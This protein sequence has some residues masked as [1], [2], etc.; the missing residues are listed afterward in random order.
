MTASA[1]DALPHPAGRVPAGPSVDAQEVAGHKA[2]RRKRYVVWQ[3]PALRVLGFA[4]LTLVVVADQASTGALRWWQVGP[5]AL[6]FLGYCMGSWLAIAAAYPRYP[7]VGQVFLAIDPFVWM[8]AVHVTGGSESWLYFLPLV[9]VADQLNSTRRL[10][11]AFAAIAVA[12]YATLLAY[13]ELV[14]GEAL[15]WWTQLGRLGF[16]AGCG[17]YL[18]VTAGTAERLRAQ[19]SD[20][21]RTARESVHRLEHQSTLLEEARLVAEEANR[22]KSEFLANVSHE[23][24]TPLNAIIGYAELL[25]EEMAAAPT[26]VHAD[27]ERISRSAHHLRGL[28][29]DVLALSQAEAGRVTLAVAPFRVDGLLRDVTSVVSPLARGQGT[30]LYVQC[31]RDVG[32]MTADEAKLRQ[33]LIN[34]VGNA[35]KFTRGGRIVLAARR[36]EAADGLDEVVFTVADTGEG[37]TPEQLT[38]IRRCEPFVQAEPSATRRHGGTG[39]GL[40]I[41]HRFTSL[42]GGTLT[43]DSSA[44]EGTT[45]TVQLPAIVTG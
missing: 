34:L 16:L 43:I 33:V 8:G 7:A 29:N 35:V 25:N 22:A 1:L 2:R 39:L 32:E 4:I 14:G 44:G 11:L 24:R 23:F 37:M 17:T 36:L 19:L 9:R 18:A 40:A 45:V 5:M 38:R 28:V 13:E 31:H 21:V 30:Q 3:V 12:A 15:A 42:M 26:A 20:A 41:A 6:G 10:A 27:L